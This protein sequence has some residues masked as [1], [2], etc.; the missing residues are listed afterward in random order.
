[1]KP[2]LIVL[3]FL[4]GSAASAQTYVYVSNAEDGD[5]GMYKLQ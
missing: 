3:A 1:M 2:I 5:I 4:F